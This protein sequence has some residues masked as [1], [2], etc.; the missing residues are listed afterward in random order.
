MYYYLIVNRY[1]ENGYLW[2]TYASYLTIAA[3]AVTRSVGILM[4][5]FNMAA[6][7][8]AIINPASAVVGC[9]VIWALASAMIAPKAFSLTIGS[10]HFDR[11]IRYE[12]MNGKCNNILRDPSDGLHYYGLYLYNVAIYI[13]LFF[14]LVSYIFISTVLEVENRRKQRI[15]NT[16]TQV[17]VRQIQVTLV[18]LSVAVMIFGLPL[19]IIANITFEN[20][21]TRKTAFAAAWGWY[22]W[23]YAANF[24][25]YVTTLKDFR[26][27]FKQVLKEF[28]FILTVTTFRNDNLISE[29]S[30]SKLC[31]TSS[32]ISVL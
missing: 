11:L 2:T 26:M 6:K 24:V 23:M 16:Q 25:L 20:R 9:V 15:L 7:A 27:M 31:S 8:K 12:V 13:P 3:I 18:A 10:Y 19:V 1:T 29:M 5:R 32:T 28:I 14:I 21:D 17:P 4:S 30:S 22:Y